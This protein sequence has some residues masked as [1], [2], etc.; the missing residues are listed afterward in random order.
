MAWYL[1]VILD[2]R[3]GGTELVCG[4]HKWTMSANW[5]VAAD[6]NSGDW[7]HVFYAHGSIPKITPLQP[8]Q[9][10]LFQHSDLRMQIAPELLG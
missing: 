9:P 1:D 8:N 3:A 10:P 2:R 6:N 7:Y 5:K 4:I